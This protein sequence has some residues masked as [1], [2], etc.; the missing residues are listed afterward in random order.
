MSI[1]CTVT[2]IN[3]PALG[4]HQGQ[5]MGTQLFGGLCFTNRIRNELHAVAAGVYGY[6]FRFFRII[7]AIPAGILAYVFRL[8]NQVIAFLGWFVCLF[9]GRMNPGM[10]RRSGRLL[11]YEIQ[12]YGYAYLLTDR[13]PSLSE[14]ADF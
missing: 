8:V 10:A 14:A 4:G 2:V 1:K 3:L 13:Y 7:L 9:T 6:L 11:S 12:F 5:A